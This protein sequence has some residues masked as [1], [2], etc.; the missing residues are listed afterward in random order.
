MRR[1]PGTIGSLHTCLW[2]TPGRG[3][4]VFALHGFTGSGADFAPL[5]RALNLP[6]LAPDLPGHGGADCPP[7]GGCALPRVA[8]GLGQL[9]DRWGARVLLG[10]SLG[11]RHALELAAQ[12]PARFDALVLIGSHAGLEDDGARAARASWDEEWARTA[13]LTDPDTFTDTWNLLPIIRSQARIPAPIYDG[14]LARRRR[15]RGRGLAA[16]LRGAGTGAMQPLW[17]ALPSLRLPTLLVVGEEDDAY[18]DHA[19]RM[20]RLLPDATVAPIPDAG[21][22][23][24]LEQVDTTAEAIAG[25]LSRARRS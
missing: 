24:H 4:R 23:A 12:S 10:Y 6:L 3:P 14:M 11:G 15:N 20:A 8:R 19:E 9:A 25:F 5:A 22:C 18:R 17:G 1:R 21:H 2:T 16:S 13:E 7:P